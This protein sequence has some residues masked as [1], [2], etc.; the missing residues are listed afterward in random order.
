MKIIFWGLGSIGS[1]HARL[2]KKNFDFEIFAY[3]TT[4]NSPNQL[5]IEEIYNLEDI[6]KIKPDV[7][8]VTNPTSM[9][10]QSIHYAASQ[11]LHLFIEKPL[12]DKLS[13]EL[14]DSLLLIKK[15]RLFTYIACQLRFHPVIQYIKQIIK[16]KTIYVSRV[17]CSSYLPDWRSERDYRTVYSAKKNMGGGVL[18][19][20]IHEPDYCSWLFGQIKKIIG[21]YG[22]I[23]HLE[24]DTEDF[25][26]YLVI[27]DSG[28]YSSIHLDYFGQKPQRIIEIIGNN[29][30]ISGDLLNNKITTFLPEPETVFFE[31]IQKDEI[32]LR[33]LLYFFNCIQ[34]N[35]QPMNSINDH[36]KIL[37]PV[38]NFKVCLV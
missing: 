6:K 13:K 34:K 29:F 5:D 2:I 14:S 16:N 15:K 30:Q 17:I 19:D 36:L 32:Y 24:I 27:H 28:I 1:R 21:I 12:C 18:L 11:N 8:F 35:I 31:P 26:N 20:L 23:S 37:K 22:K 9:H 38:L 4:S 3:R 10:I 7:A 25:A 33:Q